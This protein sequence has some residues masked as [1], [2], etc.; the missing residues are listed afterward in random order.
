MSDD[1]LSRNGTFV[2]GERI[3]GRHRLRD[4]DVFQVGG[5]AIA[6]RDPAAATTTAG[7]TVT[8]AGMLGSISVTDA[9]RRVLVALCGPFK[10]GGL[11]AAPAG[12]RE[13]ADELVLSVA[14]VKT[15]LRL[16]YDKFGIED[17]PQ[18]EKRL[19]LVAHT[20]ASGVV[21]ERDL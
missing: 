12:N 3:T 14:A 5:T 9:Q 1:G 2:R 17:L 4:A 21:T 19:Q 16:L 10:G 6:Y 20:F 7:A 15:H 13:I 11:Y 8:G 18:R